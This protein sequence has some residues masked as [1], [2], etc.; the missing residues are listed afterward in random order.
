MLARTSKAAARLSEQIR[1]RTT[2]KRY[3]A[4]VEGVLDT[5]S[6][7][8]AWQ[9]VTHWM[10]KNEAAERMQVAAPHSSGAQ[11]A[12]LRLRTKATQ[13]NRTLVEIELVTGRKHQIRVQLAE[14][15]HCILGDKKYGA[16]TS[17]RNGIALHCEHLIIEHPTLRT[18]LTFQAPLPNYWPE[19]RG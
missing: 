19:A 5:G 14:L 15:G 9:T 2:S 12:E 4:W 10:S 7:P 17:F 3:L 11:Q 1:N 13:S 8:T 18:T 16:Q 6:N